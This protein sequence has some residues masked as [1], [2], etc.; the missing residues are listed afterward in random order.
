MLLEALG[1]MRLPHW[2]ASHDELH[3]DVEHFYHPSRKQ[4]AQELRT[5]RSVAMRLASLR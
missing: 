2:R 4:L 1:D 3:E 5:E